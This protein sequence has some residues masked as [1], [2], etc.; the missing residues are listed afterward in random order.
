[1][2]FD[3]ALIYLDSFTRP[4]VKLKSSE[5]RKARNHRYYDKHKE[6]I[7]CKRRERY[8]KRQ[9]IVEIIPNEK[10]ILSGYVKK[11]K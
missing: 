8:A 2:S 10:P 6:D 4:E 7:K 1:M 11:I 3:E 5:K 9:T